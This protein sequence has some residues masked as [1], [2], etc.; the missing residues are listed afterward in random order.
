MPTEAQLKAALGEE[1]FKAYQ[2]FKTL[3]DKRAKV[4]GAKDL[5][6]TMVSEVDGVRGKYFE[7]Y[8]R[9]DEQLAALWEKVQAEARKEMGIE[10]PTKKAE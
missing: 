2:E 10:E 4:Q 3:K 5:A 1:E 9:L 6:R 7:V 8:N